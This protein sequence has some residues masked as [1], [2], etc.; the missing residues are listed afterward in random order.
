MSEANLPDKITLKTFLQTIAPLQN[1]EVQVYCRK[2]Q[3]VSWLEGTW[4]ALELN[5]AFCGGLRHSDATSADFHAGGSS[6]DLK[7]VIYQ[8]RNCRLQ[9]KTYA[10]R[11]TITPKGQFAEKIGESPEFGIKVD[12]D[13]CTLSEHNMDLYLKGLKAESAGLGLAA[14]LYYRRLVEAERT[15]L[16]EEVIALAQQFGA[17]PDYIARLEKLKQH[18]RFQQSIDEIKDCVPQALLI[19]GE[20]PFEL[21]H[22]VLSD[23]IHDRTDA[24]ALA[25][26]GE[27]RLILTHF[28]RR[29]SEMKADHHGLKQAVESLV[30]RKKARGMPLKAPV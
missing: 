18:F 20:N 29:M 16:F 30:N 14:F 10:L 19:H 3:Q 5:C 11:L 25:I 8:C 1:L 13:L 27:I 12:A 6:S 2:A 26:A 7:F 23:A 4:P 15:H 9:L 24:E 17:L 21:L 22:P 28:A